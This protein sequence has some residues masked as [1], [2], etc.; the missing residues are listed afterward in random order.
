MTQ[1]FK[2]AG[3]MV[4][5]VEESNKVFS[6]LENIEVLVGSKYKGAPPTFKLSRGKG[7]VFDMGDALIMDENN[8]VWDTSGTAVFTTLEALVFDGQLQITVRAESA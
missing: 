4:R 6:A 1:K 7:L 8:V 3:S 2:G 5:F